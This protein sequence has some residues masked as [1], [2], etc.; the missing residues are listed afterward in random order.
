MGCAGFIVA[1]KISRE[2]LDWSIVDRYILAFALLLSILVNL[3]F[4][5]IIYRNQGLE[6][7]TR[8]LQHARESLGDSVEANKEK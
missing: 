8:K 1:A 7:L 5:V 6:S 3:L 2:A 4:A